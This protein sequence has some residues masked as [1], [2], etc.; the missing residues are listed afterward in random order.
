MKEASAARREATLFG[1]PP[2]PRYASSPRPTRSSTSARCS[3]QEFCQRA[4]AKSHGNYG[5]YGFYIGLY[6][7]FLSQVGYPVNHNF[8]WWFPKM[9]PQTSSSI[10]KMGL[11]LTNHRF[12][13]VPPFNLCIDV[14]F[15]L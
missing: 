6:G 2:R 8:I 3:A 9:V 13:G 15:M 1:P 10:E 11:S 4:G 7:G 5:N 14:F 12:L